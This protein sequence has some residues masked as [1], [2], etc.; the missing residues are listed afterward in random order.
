MTRA[1]E[2]TR[3]YVALVDEQDYE[4]VAEYRWSVNRQSTVTYAKTRINGRTAYLHRFILGITD[5]RVHVDHRDHDGLNN[6]RS[7]LRVC[8]HSE[9]HCNERKR[10]YASSRY[11]GV[12][13]SRQYGKWRASIEVTGR[14]VH[15]G[16]F[17]SELDAALAYDIA[18]R[19]HF[20]EFACCN[21]PPK[22]PSTSDAYLTRCVSI[23][24]AGNFA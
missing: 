8:S 2:L 11:K 12:S 17:T 20:G 18:A 5:P 4:R 24:G 15:L 1:V 23:P 6:R 22:R 14:Y 7:N 13:W 10:R 21:F 3:G 9:N 19:T 16:R